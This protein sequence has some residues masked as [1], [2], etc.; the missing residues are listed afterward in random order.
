MSV[1]KQDVL[2]HHFILNQQDISFLNQR[3]SLKTKGRAEEPELVQEEEHES[4]PD[5]T[6]PKQEMDNTIGKDSASLEIKEEPEELELQQMKKDDYQLGSLQI[7]KIEVEDI[8]QDE[9]QDVLDHEIDTLIGTNSVSHQI[10]EEPVELELKEIKEL[11]DGSGLEQMGS[12]DENQEVPKEEI[13]ILIL[14]LSDDET[15]HQRLELNGTQIIFQN[16]PEADHHQGIETN[17]ASGS[18]RDKR[19]QKTRCGNEEQRMKGKKIQ[20]DK[21]LKQCKVCHKSFKFNCGL[22]VHMRT[23]TGEKPFSCIICGKS[24]NQ[25]GNLISHMRTHTG[26]KPF[27]C[28]TCGKCFNQKHIL[29]CH[30]RTHTG[31]KPFSCKTCGK[32]FRHKNDLNSHMRIHTSEKPFSCLTCGMGFNTKRN[33]TNHMTNHTGEKP[34]SCITCGKSFNQKGHLNRHMRT[35]TGEKPFPCMTCGKC[36]NQRGSLT[37]HMRT[38]TGEK[39]FSCIICGKGFNAK[40]NL[41]NHV[42]NHT[43]EKPF[44]CGTCGKGFSHKKS[45]TNHVIIH[46]K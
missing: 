38:H 25:K 17:E 12:Q 33:L 42:R 46:T 16:I 21:K 39:P 44:S 14:K 40:R 1:N 45:L 26:E 32:C 4:E 31:E 27:S 36:F 15:D 11:E 41:T 13:D 43:G 22:T 3:E 6:A 35:H 28:L 24:F 18:H 10:K 29:N 37:S 34:F 2:A 19:Q 7:V 20:K 30:M 9:N 23:H 8:S 5:L